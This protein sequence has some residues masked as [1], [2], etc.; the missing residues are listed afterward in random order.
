MNFGDVIKATTRSS[1]TA[2]LLIYVALVVT[3]SLLIQIFIPVIW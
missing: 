2:R 1:W 3:A